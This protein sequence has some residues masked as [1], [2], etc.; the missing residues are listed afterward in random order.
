LEPD[1]QG[2][3]CVVSLAVS[4]EGAQGGLCIWVRW[5]LWLSQTG[6]LRLWCLF[7]S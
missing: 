3:M 7:S 2:S 6:H 1:I 5:S 4:P